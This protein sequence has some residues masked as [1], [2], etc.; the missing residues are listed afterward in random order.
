MF[1]HITQRQNTY[2][3]NNVLDL[4]IYPTIYISCGFELLSVL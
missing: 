2:D 3:I 4:Y 1:L